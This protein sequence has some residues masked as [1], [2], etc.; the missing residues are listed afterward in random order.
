MR[1]LS[2]VIFFTILGIF[3]K[4]LFEKL[5]I[6]LFH[7]HGGV[8]Q[9]LNLG[10]IYRTTTLKFDNFANNFLGSQLYIETNKEN[11]RPIVKT[12]N[13]IL[14]PINILDIEN[15]KKSGSMRYIR[16]GPLLAVL[17]YLC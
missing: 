13:S 16:P 2:D 7:F 3:V 14:M 11:M 17:S 6:L 10:H 9:V 12:R 5:F 4:K 15:A 1:R 8:G